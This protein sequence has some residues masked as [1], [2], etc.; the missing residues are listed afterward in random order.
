MRDGMPSN[1]MVSATLIQLVIK[2]EDLGVGGGGESRK[3]REK[4]EGHVR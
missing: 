2:C 4:R 1:K 3:I